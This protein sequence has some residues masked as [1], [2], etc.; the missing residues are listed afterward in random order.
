MVARNCLIGIVCL[1]LWSCASAEESENLVEES[2]E[3][4]A[5]DV[6]CGPDSYCRQGACRKVGGESSNP[7]AE[8]GD[9]RSS[10]DS[11]GTS[12]GVVEGC[13]ATLDCV[14]STCDEDDLTCWELCANKLESRTNPFWVGYLGCVA[15][16]CGECSD[17]ACW[18]DCSRDRCGP[19]WVSCVTDGLSGTGNCSEGAA[20]DD[21]CQASDL[22]CF[23]E[24][25]SPVESSAQEAL[26]EWFKC[27][28]QDSDVEV[29]LAQQLEC[30]QSE[31]SCYCPEEIAGS[32][33]GSCGDYWTCIG[34][35]EDSCCVATCRANMSG[36][37]LL[38]AD[39][40]SLCM[41]AP[42]AE[43]PEGDSACISQCALEYCANEVGACYCPGTGSPGSGQ[44]KCG[45]A[46]K[47]VQD[48][49]EGDA[50]CV[51]ECAAET[52]SE[53]YDKLLALLDCL[54]S[55][56]CEDGDEACLG[57]CFTPVVGACA[58][59]ALACTVD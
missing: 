28:N 6:N 24:C 35:C 19:S 39:A 1:G 5:S 7:A 9:S 23:S 48:C 3:E 21:D 33:T 47:C 14:E 46:L 29:D 37:A 43:C 34:D 38:S 36:A 44:G 27:E 49:G 54:P 20:C 55:C 50:C 26:G 13:R 31:I 57:K 45:A 4:C 52:R 17:Y 58:A 56:G 8:G 41:A 22:E 10:E 59:E 32:G 18:A 16:E 25:F 53:G 51:A 40:M 15:A 42:C 11:S 12:V 2:R 30:Y